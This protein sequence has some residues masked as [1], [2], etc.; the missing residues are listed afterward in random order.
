MVLITFHSSAKKRKIEENV[1]DMGEYL[2][3]FTTSKFKK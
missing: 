2:N 1:N 3:Y